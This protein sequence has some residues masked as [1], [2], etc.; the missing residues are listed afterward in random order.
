MLEEFPGPNRR[1]IL[2]EYKPINVSMGVN[3]VDCIGTFA[4]DLLPRPQIRILANNC[5]IRPEILKNGEI[6]KIL[7]HGNSVCKTTTDD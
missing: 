5:F 3:E 7:V 2:G 4:L 1:I 6:F